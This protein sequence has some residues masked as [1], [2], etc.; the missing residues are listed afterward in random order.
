[1]ISLAGVDPAGKKAL[2]IGAGDCRLSIELIRQGALQVFA[3]EPD[4]AMV[5]Y[6]AI[7]YRQQ[8]DPNYMRLQI[9]SQTIQETILPWDTFDLVFA[10]QSVNYWFN[11]TTDVVPTICKSMTPGG[12]FVFNTF[13]NKP[14]PPVVKQYKIDGHDFVEVSWMVDDKVNHIQIR[15]DMLPHQTCFDW[16]SPGELWDTLTP[17]FAVELRSDGKTDLYRCVKR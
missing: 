10:Q 11:A 14:V 5:D 2:D 7:F 6:A 16:I 1:M 8:M 9:V 15:D 12:I 4:P 13:H 17:L 3:I